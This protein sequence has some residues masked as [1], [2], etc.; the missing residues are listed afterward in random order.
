MAGLAIVSPVNYTDQDLQ[1]ANI[2]YINPIEGAWFDFAA[3]S[4]PVGTEVKTWESSVSTHKFLYTGGNTQ[5]PMTKFDGTRRYLEFDGV[6][7]RLDMDHITNK[8][9]LLW[10]VASYP[11]TGGYPISSGGIGQ[12]F[13]MGRYSDGSRFSFSDDT[14]V[15]PAE[16][17]DNNW[18]VHIIQS[19]GTNS[20]Y[21]IDNNAKATGTL[22]T[23]SLSHTRLGATAQQYAPMKLSRYGLMTGV[24]SDAEQQV[25]AAK[26]MDQYGIV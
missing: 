11:G 9:Y 7:D 16:A 23:T 6:N 1:M 17:G 4:V 13:L 5:R 8:P 20:S 18:H 14:N 10:V 15:V 24:Y 22:S 2:G 12:L 26:L 21:K 25:I 3:E 19:N